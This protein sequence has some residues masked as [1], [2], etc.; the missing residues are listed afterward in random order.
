MD[1]NNNSDSNKYLWLVWCTCGNLS[2]WACLW[3]G[4]MYE[5][6]VINF[7]YSTAFQGRCYYVLNRQDQLKHRFISEIWKMNRLYD[8]FDAHK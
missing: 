8:R 7:F 2:W 3:V 6:G 5:Y 1:S 4:D